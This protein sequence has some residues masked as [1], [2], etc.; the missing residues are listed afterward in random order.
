MHLHMGLH[1]LTSTPDEKPKIT[2]QL[3]KRV[4]AYASPYRWPILGMLVLILSST[5]LMLLAPLVMRRLI[6]RTI[7]QKDLRGLALLTAVLILIPALNGILSVLQ[8]RLNSQVGEGVIY[9]L[10][11]ALYANLQRMSLRFFT[12][13]R[14][15]ELMSRLN[16]DVIGAQNAIS[17][18]IV[19]MITS[20]VQACA[21]LAYSRMRMKTCIRKELSA[22]PGMS[23]SKPRTAMNRSQAAS[24]PLIFFLTGPTNRKS[25]SF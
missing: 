11:M 8:R 13:T 12:N 17:N 3:L 24:L 5:G 18:T 20:F 1:G 16:N 15:G 7:P 4:L 23:G 10:R 14:V 19:G 2:R 22:T 6:D 21:M 25:P 9:D